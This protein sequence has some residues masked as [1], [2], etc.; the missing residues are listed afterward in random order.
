[1]DGLSA[2]DVLALTKDNGGFLDGG[3]GWII[4]L[5]IFIWAVFGGNG[6]GARGGDYVSQA[7]LQNGLYN[8]TTDRNLSDIRDAQAQNTMALNTSILTTNY[9]GLLNAKDL[10]AQLA[11]CCCATQKTII[12][13]NQLTRDAITDLKISELADR[14]SLAR[15]QIS[16]YEQSAYILNQLGAYYQKP[17]VNPCTCYNTTMCGVY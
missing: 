8:Q 17:A 4:L 3:I 15:N 7:E 10:Q 16:N 5:F 2:S 14:L 1:M 12:E 11:S 6:F 9:N 13:Q